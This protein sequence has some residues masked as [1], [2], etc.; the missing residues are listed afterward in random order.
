MLKVSIEQAMDK[1]NRHIERVAAL[2]GEN[3]GNSDKY[4]EDLQALINRKQDLYTS[5]GYT[6]IRFTLACP[7]VKLVDKVLGSG[8][9]IKAL[10]FEPCDTRR[11]NLVQPEGIMLA[12]RILDSGDL[13]KLK[14]VYAFLAKHPLSPEDAAITDINTFIRKVTFILPAAKVEDYELKRTYHYLASQI[15]QAA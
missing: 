13:A 12:L 8:I 9:D 14:S 1:K 10:A 15:W 4:I 7:D 11:F 6:K 3:V 5:L 2:S